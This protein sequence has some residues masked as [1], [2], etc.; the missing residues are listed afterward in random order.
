MSF[1]RSLLISSLGIVCLTAF[2]GC[3]GSDDNV[4]PSA[5]GGAGGAAPGTGA[6]P[7]SGGA[8]ASGGVTGS[9]GGT[10]TASG[11]TTTGSGGAAACNTDYSKLPAG[12][13]VS[14]KNDLMP[15]FG[16]ACVA[17]GCHGDSDKKA[18]L[19]LG[20]KCAFDAAAKWR[21][22]FPTA[23]GA[24]P[25]DPQPLTDDIVAQVFASLTAQSTTAPAIKRADPTKPESSFI[26]DKTSNT[27]SAKGLQCTNQ[28]PSH[29]ATGAP[30]G[31]YMP[32]TGDPLCTSGPTG[33]ARFDAIAQWIKNGA[34]NN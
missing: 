8:A 7:A 21:C 6:A 13:A 33:Q 22:T 18:G 23:P 4:G 34:Q 27:Q 1:D 5:T 20:K 12:A 14:L 26:L 28:D 15:I 30:C 25:T 2:A 19:Y 24:T 9:T 17:S 10:T 32:A 29:S 31:D 3:S 11:G 16:L